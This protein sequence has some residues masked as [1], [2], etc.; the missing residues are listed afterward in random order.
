MPIRLTDLLRRVPAEVETEVKRVRDQTRSTLQEALRTECRLVM[1]TPEDTEENRAGAQVPVEVAPGYPAVLEEI[2]FP[3][4]LECILLL[5]RYRLGL[6]QAKSGAKSLLLLREELL[7]RPNPERWLGASETELQSTARWAASLLNLLDQHDPLKTV[8]AVRDDFLGVYEY[9]T[10]GLFDDEYTVN[11]AKIIIY[12]GVIGLVSE[13]MGCS[14]SDLTIVVL[15]HELAHAYTQLGADI[16]GRRWPAQQF[17]QADCGLKEGLAQYYTERILT[18]LERKYSGALKV[19]RTM[20]PRQQEAYRTH[21]PWVKDYSPEAVR[22]ATL[23]V[24]RWNEGKVADF[25]RRLAQA[26][27]ELRPDKRV[28]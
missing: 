9:Y 25:N 11:R 23:E 28:T 1:R 15:V 2:T 22:R 20:L 16:D 13:W 7:R 24:R 5:S 12:W 3:G 10:D 6:E 4:E 19:Y 18:R 21:L 14:V 27:K 8:L 17:S 26:Q